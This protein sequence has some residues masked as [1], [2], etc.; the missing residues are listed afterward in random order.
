MYR[1]TTWSRRRIDNMEQ[2]KDDN[3]EQEKDR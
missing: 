3:M 1:E 2:E